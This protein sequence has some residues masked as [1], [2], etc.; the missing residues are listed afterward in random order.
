[1]NSRRAKMRRGMSMT[2][3]AARRMRMLLSMNI[4]TNVVVIPIV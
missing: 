2:W 3:R 4:N 1:M